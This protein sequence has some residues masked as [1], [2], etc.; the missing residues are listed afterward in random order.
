M[1]W[2]DRLDDPAVYEYAYVTIEGT[3]YLLTSQELPASMVPTGYEQIVCLDLGPGIVTPQSALQRK[4]GVAAP[5]TM[6]LRFGP[7]G[8][9]RLIS[10]LAP[11]GA[12][13]RA[14]L[15]SD[16]A[17]GDTK[18]YCATAGGPTAG[19]YVYLGREAYLIDSVNAAYFDLGSVATGRE[20]LD[21][22][23]WTF[24]SEA[25]KYVTNQPEVFEGRLARVWVGYADHTG[26]PL[27]SALYDPSQAE[28]FAGRI[29]SL[30][31]GDDWHSWTMRLKGLE[32]F[33]DVQVGGQGNKTG[34]LDQFSLDATSTPPAS[35]YQQATVYTGQQWVYLTAT[36]PGGTTSLAVELDARFYGN[37]IDSVADAIQTA[38]NAD[39]TLTS[40]WIVDG[41]INTEYLYAQ[42]SGDAPDWMSTFRLTL[43]FKSS[44]ASATVSLMD[45]VGSLMPRLGFTAADLKP[46][47]QKSDAGQWVFSASEAP[48]ALYLGP[49]DT[50][51]H[52]YTDDIASD[53]P[54]S[55]FVRIGDADSGEIVEYSSIIAQYAGHIATLGGLRRGVLGTQRREIK[56]PWTTEVSDDGTS[57]AGVSQMVRV[58]VFVAREQTN[59]LTAILEMLAST[60]TAGTRDATYDVAAI[61][62]G[63]GASMRLDIVDTDRF[64]QLADVLPT[65]LTVRD[66]AWQE[67]FSLREWLSGELSFLGLTLQGRRLPSRRFQLTLDRV[68]DPVLLSSATLTTADLDLEAGIKIQRVSEGIVNQMTAQTAWNPAT[69]EWEDRK[70]IINDVDSQEVYG[71]RPAMEIRARGM[72]RQISAQMTT[73]QQQILSVMAHY[74]RPYEL[75][76]FSASRSAWRYQPGDQIA[77]TH[78]AVP[79]MDGTRGWVAEPL[80][81]LAVTPRYLGS[82]KKA[83]ADL[84]CLHMGDRRVSYYVPSALVTSYD[85][86]T[87]TATLAANEFSDASVPYPLDS[88][89]NCK[90]V[91]WFDL[92]GADV[93]VGDEGDSSVRGTYEIDHASITPSTLTI[94]TDLSAALQTAISAG[95]RVIVWYP[96]HDD[97]SSVQQLYI[98]LADSSGTLGAAGDDAFQ[99]SG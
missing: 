1:A 51:V 58:T 99:Y 9:D 92:S 75:V 60:G 24:R 22:V 19:E 85:S 93:Y 87:K 70:W 44:A 5:A 38:L 54:S 8:S 95:K 2:I 67:T 79:N 4:S 20:Q 84:V 27:D 62:E 12:S 28:V 97:C 17:Y 3:P 76:R 33:L 37:I 29:E 49:D 15:T 35:A 34:R 11:R 31:V 64:E 81:V 63:F 21:S 94:T 96:K 59:I 30:S 69:G 18:I 36:D 45:G 72:A 14:E 16:L 71:K 80:V 53:W 56:L 86:G 52:V 25:R 90:D 47:S 26:A 98:H 55:G 7:R 83:A 66:L 88:S 41:D 39:P 6:T 23:Q 61:Y 89:V 73:V 78:P 82:G 48:L 10:A 77:L 42:T 91:R 68:S 65:T 13:W 40:T 57:V 43:A 32:A 74:S 50:S 46:P